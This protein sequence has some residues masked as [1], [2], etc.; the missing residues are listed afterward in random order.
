MA[1]LLDHDLEAC[2]KAGIDPYVPRPQ[3]GPSVRAVCFV[4]MNSATAQPATAS[5]ARRLSIFIP[6]RLL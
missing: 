1:E 2:E 4:K 5:S 6:I 3:R